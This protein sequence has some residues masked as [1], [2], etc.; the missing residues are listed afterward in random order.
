[1]HALQ[2][3]TTRRH[4][5]IQSTLL[6][7]AL[8]FVVSETIRHVVVDH[9]DRLHERIA[10]RRSDE[11]EPTLPQILAH[12]IGLESSRRNAVEGFPPVL[13]W[14][15]THELPE[16]GVEAAKLLLHA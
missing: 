14:S 15:P 8:Y 5:S 11:A 3:L 12:C 16:V 9:S 10:D 2:R 6:D 7:G 4:C 1:M 13:Y